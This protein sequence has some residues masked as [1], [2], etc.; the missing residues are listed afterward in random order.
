MINYFPKIYEH[1][2]FYSV[3]S[4]LKQDINVQ[5]NQSF[6]EIVFKQPHEYIEIFYVNEP[7]DTL[8]S[9]MSKNYIVNDLYYNHTM[10]F[11][12]SLF[13]NIALRQERI[14]SFVKEEN[15]IVAAVNSLSVL[16]VL[17]L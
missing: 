2:L 13:L 8:Y 16:L 12:W 15:T 4:R 11:Y 9:F 5:N 3:Y 17:Q 1:E 6:K 14:I 10:F 7:S